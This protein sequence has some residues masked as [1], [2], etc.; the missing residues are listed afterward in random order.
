MP[1]WLGARTRMPGRPGA[2]TRMPGR[3]GTRTSMP[4]RLGGRTRMPGR[5]GARTSMPG[6]PGTRTSTPASAAHRALAALA[7]PLEEPAYPLA[8]IGSRPGRPMRRRTPAAEPAAAI[9]AAGAGLVP[10][11]ALA[12]A[13]LAAGAGLVPATG[14][15]RVAGV[16]LRATDAHL[17]LC[18]PCAPARG[19]AGSDCLLR[20]RRLVLARL[21]LGGPCPL[22]QAQQAGEEDQ[23]QQAEQS[24]YRAGRRG[25]TERPGA[26]ALWKSVC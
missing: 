5:P 2:R 26:A 10:A 8:A 13:I 1:G 21:A 7:Y 20:H 12:A 18:T 25:A 3:L 23:G 19:P 15:C 16:A 4:G 17:H 6:R 11:T 9:L 24:V 22:R 14:L